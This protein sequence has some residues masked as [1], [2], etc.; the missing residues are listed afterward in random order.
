MRSCRPSSSLA[1]TFRLPFLYPPRARRHALTLDGQRLSLRPSTGRG[2]SPSACHARRSLHGRRN[3]ERSPSQGYVPFEAADEEELG[4]LDRLGSSTS[5]TGRGSTITAEERAT[6]E[7]IFKDIVKTT[8]PRRDR[9]AATPVSSP[10]DVDDDKNDKLEDLQ[11]I[12]ASVT[13]RDRHGRERSAQLS[14]SSADHRDPNLARHEPDQTQ[15]RPWMSYPQSL[16]AAAAAATTMR[17]LQL[18]ASRAGPAGTHEAT[19]G[20]EHEA[21][22]LRGEHI[23]GELK[24]VEGLL[25]GAMTDLE[26]WTILEREVFSGIRRLEK[27]LGTPE[28]TVEAKRQAS[29]GPGEAGQARVDETA[30]PPSPSPPNVAVGLDMVGPNYP[31]LVLLAMRM[32][33]YEFGQPSAC[34][35]LF[36]RVKSLG[37]ISYVLGATTA[38]YNEMI[39][40][41]WRSYADFDAVDELLAEMDKAGVDFDE[42]THQLVRGIGHERSEARRGASGPVTAALWRMGR[43]ERGLQ[44]VTVWEAVARRKVQERAATVGGGYFVHGPTER[45]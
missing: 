22:D 27:H 28:T 18:R 34:L 9:T 31:H 1:G 38:L 42:R 8:A 21:V 36:H 23:R 19:D 45:L 25:R 20:V 30:P 15:D 26:V 6:F 16:R 10:D 5:G 4:E 2:S 3:D 11:S 29:Q 7:R 44:K 40:L 32:F 14:F 33:R 35:T 37:S 41:R 43:L 12:L 13:S 24:R 39:A 17:R